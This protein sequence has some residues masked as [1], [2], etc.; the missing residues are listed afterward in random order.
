MSQST[1]PTVP[2]AYLNIS[3]KQ[4][5]DTKYD[6]VYQRVY[7]GQTPTPQANT[8]NVLTSGDL[9]FLQSAAGVASQ[10][11]DSNN[12]DVLYHED[13]SYNAWDPNTT[14]STYLSYGTY[15]Y[16]AKSYVPSYEDS[17]YLSRSHGFS[18]GKQ[19]NTTNPVLSIGDSVQFDPN[20]PFYKSWDSFGSNYRGSSTPTPIPTTTPSVSVES[21]YKKVPINDPN[22]CENTQ[23]KNKDIEEICK[24]IPQDECTNYNCCVSIGNK[25]CVSGDENGPWLSSNYH[26][27]SI[28]DRDYYYYKNKCYGS[29]L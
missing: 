21:L 3:Q 2:L 26:D 11:F 8:S 7:G 29:C 22:F 25:K 19:S 28:K 12:Y 10:Y 6:S 15:K 18:R 14:Y 16:G 1:A 27:P 5:Y 20:D 13:Y 24:N 4:F 23:W 17:V 9:D